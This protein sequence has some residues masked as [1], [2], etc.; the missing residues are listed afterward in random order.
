MIDENKRREWN[1]LTIW[2]AITNDARRTCGMK[3]R[4]V[5]AKAAFNKNSFVVRK[6]KEETSKHYIW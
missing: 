4:S 3:Y 1:I 5:M 2:I 6:L